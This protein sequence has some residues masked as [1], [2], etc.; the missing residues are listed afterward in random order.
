[1]TVT[2]QQL[3]DIR[4]ALFLG[5]R[6][7]GEAFTEALAAAGDP[8][9]EQLALAALPLMQSEDRNER[10]LALRFIANHASDATAAAVLA[11]LSDPA[12]RVR[13]VALKSCAK[14]MDRREFVDR[15]R[16]MIEDDGEK[17]RLRGGALLLL[18]G[19]MAAWASSPP[20]A[21][22]IGALRD[23]TTLESYRRPIL[24]RLVG[25][26]QMTPAVKELLN[27]FVVDGTKEEAV[28]ATR[29]LAG[30]RMAHVGESG[31]D[32]A[33]RRE[34]EQTH[35]RVFPDTVWFWVRR[36]EPAQ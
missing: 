34:F 28:V 3:K 10:V 2:V 14:F 17:R 35:D 36:E 32:R 21:E 23:L 20:S 18:G 16:D 15:V 5:V 19:G 7:G 9:S 29:A 31:P 24:S 13:E 25:S 11:G 4:D 22:A 26:R 12:R 30:W 6:D 8:T 27:A 33:A 1:M